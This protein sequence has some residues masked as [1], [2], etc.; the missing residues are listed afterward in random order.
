MKAV[1]RNGYGFSFLDKNFGWHNCI[2]DQ[3]GSR[4]TKS[5]I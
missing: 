5:G 1:F 4:D 3:F 2:G